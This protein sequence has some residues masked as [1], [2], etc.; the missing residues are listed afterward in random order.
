MPADGN[1]MW[2]E[3]AEVSYFA[4]NHQPKKMMRMLAVSQVPINKL[5]QDKSVS[6][7]PIVIYHPTL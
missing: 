6:V 4:A 7:T 5:I 1:A 2:Q 3:M